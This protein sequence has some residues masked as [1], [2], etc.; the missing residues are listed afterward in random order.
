MTEEAEMTEEA[1]PDRSRRAPIFFLCSPRK[2]GAGEADPVCSH[3]RRK[4][5]SHAIRT[6]SY[7]S[8]QYERYDQRVQSQRL[9]EREPDDHR[10]EKLV[11]AVR[12]AP[13]RFHRRR[14]QLALTYPA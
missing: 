14:R 12:V 3:I 1:H 2:N 8:L 6:R 5:E 11:G 9:D 4:I 7:L 10:N 13:D